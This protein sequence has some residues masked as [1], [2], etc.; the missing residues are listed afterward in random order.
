MCLVTSDSAGDTPSGDGPGGNG[1][2]TAPLVAERAAQ[3]GPMR[4]LTVLAAIFV[5]TVLAVA[6]VAGLKL[7]LPGDAQPVWVQFSDLKGRVQL[8]YC[9]GLAG[10]F[11][12]TAFTQDLDGSSAVVPVK[13]TADE[14]GNA[15]FVDGV[16]LYLHRSSITIGAISR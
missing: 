11:E 7:F 9:P 8:G 12:G 10:N 6:V 15:K 14:C 5:A 13:V 2:D 4:L 3:R 1:A 16:W